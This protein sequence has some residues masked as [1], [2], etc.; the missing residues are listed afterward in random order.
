MTT[1]VEFVGN[2]GAGDGDVYRVFVAM[3]TVNA[4]VWRGD[5]KRVSFS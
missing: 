3:A 5:G 1:P 2:D 4:D